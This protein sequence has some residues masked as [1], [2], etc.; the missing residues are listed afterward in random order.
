M[1]A[2][3]LTLWA[4]GCAVGPNYHRPAAATPQEYKEL[5]GWKPATPRDFIDRGAW[6]SIY[7]DSQ[8]DRLERQVSISNQNIQLYQAQYAAAEALVRE[9]RSQLFPS[10][11][12]TAVATPTCSSNSS[13]SPNTSLYQAQAAATWTLDVWGSI[14][15]QLE[16]QKAAAQVS[17][18]DLANALLSAQATLAQDYFQLRAS[19]SLE[20][21]LNDVV[22]DYAGTTRIIQYQ[23]Q[24]G[25]ASRGDYMSA[26][27]QLQAAQAQLIGVREARGQYEHAIAV[28]TGTLPSEL[29]IAHAPLATE[30]PVVPVGLPST[31]LERNPN[32]AAAERQ[33]KSENALIGVAEATYFPTITLSGLGGYLSASLADLFTSANR[34]WSTGAAGSETIFNAGY[35]PAAVAAARANYA[36]AVASYRQTVLS[37][38]QSVEDQLIALHTLQDESVAAGRAVDS[39]KQA[40]DVALNEYKAG[41][42][43]FTTVLLTDEISLTDSQT[44]LTIQQNRFLASVALIEALGG[45]WDSSKL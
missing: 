4:G 39:A 23:Y 32:I 18:A 29:A 27:A 22:K 33:M 1:G 6:W 7:E 41:V 45:G 8:L 16:S 11:S 14:R 15:R 12:A 37:T 34:L 44:L 24:F 35:R 10:F 25:V 42:V 31:L 30:V 9:A 38:F 5:S 26:L 3:V 2:V 21:L 40:S 17:A 43:A 13:C 20:D 28:L 36:A 19:D